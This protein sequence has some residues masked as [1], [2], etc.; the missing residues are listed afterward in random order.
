MTEV[1][2]KDGTKEPFDPEKIK[3][4]IADTAQQAYIPEERKEEVVYQVAGTVI[5]LLESKEEIDTIDIKQAILA[6]LD[7]VEPTVASSWRKYEE[8]K[9]KVG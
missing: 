6:E 7:K 5:P 8:G 2:K 1:V 9:S 4:S 3:K